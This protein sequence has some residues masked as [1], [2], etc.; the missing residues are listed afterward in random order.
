[1]IQ[2]LLLHVALK[3]RATGVTRLTPARAVA[4]ARVVIHAD[5]AKGGGAGVAGFAIHRSTVEQLRLRN[6]V[7]HFP[8][9]P[10]GTLGCEVAVMAGFTFRGCYGGVI[11][12]DGSGEACL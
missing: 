9:R 3:G 7:R 2:G 4:Q 5:G 12:G 1:M 10:V 8:S 6:V 11:H